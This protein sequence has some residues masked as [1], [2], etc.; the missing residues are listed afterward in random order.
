[1]AD[2]FFYSVGAL[3]GSACNELY[4]G[5]SGYGTRTQLTGVC[6]QKSYEFCFS[7]VQ[8]LRSSSDIEYSNTHTKRGIFLCMKC[9]RYLGPHSNVAE[10]FLLCS[11]LIFV[12]GV[13]LTTLSIQKIFVQ[14][15]DS[16]LPF[17]DFP[18]LRKKIY[19]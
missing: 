17:S 18:L 6:I 8:Q 12:I 1:M 3:R 7:F 11:K 14:N 16:F 15:F 19:W 4:I 5:R 10:C 13:T 2:R 9:I